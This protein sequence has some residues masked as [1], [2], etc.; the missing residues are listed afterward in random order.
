MSDDGFGSVPPEL[1]APGAKVSIQHPAD[2]SQLV[3][4]FAGI[5]V[6]DALVIELVYA[7]L[8]RSMDDGIRPDHHPNVNDAPFV[9]IEER[10]IAQFGLLHKTEGISLLGLLVSIP[11]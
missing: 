9:I 1:A 11:L 6:E 5:H 8:A 7:H 3:R 10:E 2:Q 4:V